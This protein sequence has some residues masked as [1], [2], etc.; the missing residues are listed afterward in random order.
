MRDIP[1]GIVA[2]SEEEYEAVREE[3]SYEKKSSVYNTLYEEWKGECDIDYD[4]EALLAYV[5][6]SLQNGSLIHTE[7]TE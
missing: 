6:L 5:S 4:E 1:A 7:Q 3:I 2:L